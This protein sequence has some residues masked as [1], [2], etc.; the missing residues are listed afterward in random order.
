MKSIAF[1]VPYFGRFP[2]NYQLW[3]E[4]CRRNPSIDFLIFTD[5]CTK[6]EYPKN[7][8]LFHMDFKDIKQKIQKLY[9]FSLRLENPYKLCDFRPAYGEIFEE[10]LKGYD[11]W[12]HCDIDLIWG[13][14][15]SLLQ[16]MY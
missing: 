16:M 7:V 15:E 13:I 14:Y 2:I 4:S 1:I 9:N 8:K 11:Y 3:L 10:F 12:G 5:D 6:Y